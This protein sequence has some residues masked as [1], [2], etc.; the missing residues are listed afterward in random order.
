MNNRKKNQASSVRAHSQG[1]Q[2]TATTQKKKKGR[3]NA[4][5][6]DVLEGLLELVVLLGDAQLLH[7]LPRQSLRPA[8]ARDRAERAGQ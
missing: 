7:H 1:Y 4:H 2:A 6:H 8:S 5:L 3:K